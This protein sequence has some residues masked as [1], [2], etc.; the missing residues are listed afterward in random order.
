MSLLVEETRIIVT[1]DQDQD[2]PGK[3]E[4]QQDF[5]EY[6]AKGWSYA[7]IARK[8]KVAKST[9]ASWASDLEEEI[10]SAKA[11]ELEALLE[12]YYLLKESRIKLLGEQ[13]KAMEKE[14]KA[15]DL[16]KVPTEKL[17]EILLKYHQQLKEEYVEPKVLSPEKI[18]ELKALKE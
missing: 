13:I 11:M 17:L 2:R 3:L 5:I 6:R 1:Q 10:A 16:T 12:R 4:L 15:R 14:L 9:L 18:Q 8:L 7:K